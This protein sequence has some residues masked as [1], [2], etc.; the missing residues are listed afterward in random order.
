MLKIIPPLYPNEHIYSWISRY[1]SYSGNPSVQQSNLDL[2]DID[3]KRISY[4]QIIK[5]LEVFCNKF[6]S[7]WGITPWNMIREHTE[8]PLYMPFINLKSNE[9]KEIALVSSNFDV[10]KS[11]KFKLCPICYAEQIQQYGEAYFNRCHQDASVKYCNRHRK[12]LLKCIKQYYYLNFTDVNC[13]DIENDFENI[14]RY[15]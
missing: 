15:K 4:L 11:L 1:H 13:M 5:N 14:T 2:F 6:P 10:A 8:Y 9:Y 12:P 7:I 3:A